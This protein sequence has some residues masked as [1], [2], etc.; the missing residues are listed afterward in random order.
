M[1]PYG[2]DQLRALAH[3]QIARPVQHQRRLLG[4]F[5]GY[6]PHARSRHRLADGGR[7]GS[8]ALIYGTLAVWPIISA[9]L[10]AVPVAAKAVAGLALIVFALWRLNRLV[11]PSERSRVIA[12]CIVV[13]F[14][15]VFWMG[16][17]QAGG[18]MNL[19]ADKQTERTLA[20]FEVPASWFQSI[21]PFL[22]L[23][24]APFFAFFLN[25]SS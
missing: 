19:F 5:D 4:S 23:L 15:I 16:F 6:E 9:A 25:A 7:V 18:S 3:Q 11:T 22:I 17:E 8:I 13:C 10:S 1:R 24:L 12:I 21:N 2:I 20:G 14:S